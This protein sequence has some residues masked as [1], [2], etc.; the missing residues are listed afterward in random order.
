MHPEF[1]PAEG[2]RDPEVD[3]ADRA[4]RQWTW[5]GKESMQPFWCLAKL[6]PEELGKQSDAE[7][8][9]GRV[10]FNVEVEPRK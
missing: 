5:T 2:K 3:R 4:Q 9:T 10:R 8:E 1:A 7:A 6:A